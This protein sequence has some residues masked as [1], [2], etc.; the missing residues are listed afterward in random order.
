MLIGPAHSSA[1]LDAFS[2]RMPSSAPSTGHAE[3]VALDKAVRKMT[4]PQSIAIDHVFKR[5][6][7]YNMLIDASVVLTNVMKG[8]CA[9]ELAYLA[10]F[11]GVNLSF[12]SD[13]IEQ[14]PQFAIDKVDTAYNTSDIFT[15]ALEFVAF[16]RHRQGLGVLSE[17][18]FTAL[19]RRLGSQR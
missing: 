12:V 16:S 19:R 7:Q 14:R 1:T 11:P 18:E 4:L 9:S 2:G 13:L 3:F 10:K 5:E 8:E 6:L 15:K 17:Q